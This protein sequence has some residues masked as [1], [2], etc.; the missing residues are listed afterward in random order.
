[1]NYLD[2]IDLYCE[3]TDAS[4]LAEPLNAISNLSFIIAAA[5]LW[6]QYK[7]QPNK[8][9]DVT[10]LVALV[11]SVGIGS[12][13]FHTFANHLTLLS[14]VIPITMF[15]FSYLWVAMRRMIGLS[16]TSIVSWLVA[17]FLL[18]SALDAVPS[19]YNF[20]NSISY[21]PSLL[22]IATF[23]YLMKNTS[24]ESA[25]YYRYAFICFAF[26]LFFRSI[27]LSI[28]GDFTLGTHFLWHILNGIV[29]YIL[30]RITMEQSSNKNN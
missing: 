5:L 1:M 26:S 4:L 16:R 23:W 8:S 20:N 3:R 2:H 14:D 11:A 25:K 29:L 24:H 15:I 7:A 12:L 9:P 28:C 13:S 22:A 18:S 19:D 21:F 17:F 27:D 30:V 6:K 10:L